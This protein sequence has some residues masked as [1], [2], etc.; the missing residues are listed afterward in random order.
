MGLL[1][2]RDGTRDR[3]G[4]MVVPGVV[5]IVRSGSRDVGGTA[6]VAILCLVVGGAVGEDSLPRVMWVEVGSLMQVRGTV[7]LPQLLLVGVVVECYRG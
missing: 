2:A 7:L 1:V 5:G 4:G 3:L 6:G